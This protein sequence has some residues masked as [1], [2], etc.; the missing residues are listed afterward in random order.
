[1][2][3]FYIQL[4]CRLFNC[5]GEKYDWKRRRSKRSND[6]N[7]R[8]TRSTFF[9]II[10]F[11]C[12]SFVFCSQSIHDTVYVFSKLQKSSHIVWFGEET[13]D[14]IVMCM[15]TIKLIKLKKNCKQRTFHSIHFNTG[16]STD[17]GKMI[18]LFLID[19]M[20]ICIQHVRQLIAVQMKLLVLI[21]DF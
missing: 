20:N 10:G 4:Y 17:C 14:Q 21:D 8:I 2:E 1:M 9:F 12:P 19:W 11:A 7:N 16:R 6:L 13:F 3:R 5:L 18:P 15:A